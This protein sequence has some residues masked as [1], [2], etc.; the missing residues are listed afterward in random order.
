M[1]TETRQTFCRICESLC[2]LEVT[3]EDGKP[4]SIRPDGDHVATRGFACPKGLKQAALF[5]NPDRL[6][7]PMKRVGETYEPISWGQALS[8]IGAKTRLIAER[9]GAKSIGMYVGT[10]AGFGVLHPIFAQGFMMGLGSTTLY[11]PASQDCANKFAASR[12]I[13]GFP[14]LQPFPDVRNTECLIIVGANPVVSKWSFLQV[15]NPTKEIKDIIGRGGQVIVVDPRRTETAKLA[16]AHHYIQPG[17]DVFFYLSFLH[18]VLAQG[19]VNEAV[20]AAHMT[21]FEEL[22][23][24]AADWPAERTTDVTGIAPDILRN[25]V[26]AY[27]AADGA[28]LYSS[29][30]VNMG[31]NGTLAFWLQEAINAISGNL[32]RKGGTL[33]AKGVYDFPKFAHK[34]GLL[35][36]D[37]R[38]RIG[39]FPKVN[40]A[41]PGGIMADEILTPGEGQLKALFVTGGNPLL[42]MPNAGRLRDAFEELELLVCLDIQ[43]G[44]TAS[45]AHYVLPCTS[46]LERPDL[47]FIFPL[48]LGLQ[49]KPYVQATKALVAPPGEVRD[50]ATIYA[51]LANASGFPLFGSGL[52]QK[53]LNWLV[54]R[55]AR[56]DSRG[57]PGLPQEGILSLLLRITG[58]GSFG[59]LLKHPHGVARPDHEEGSFLG[60]RVLTEDGKIHLAPDMFVQAAS[61]LGQVLEGLKQE[62][63]ELR[64][65][66]KRHVKTHNSWTHNIADFVK[67][68]DGDTNHLY[69][70]PNDAMERQL[71]AGDMVDVS[72][73]VAVVRLPLALLE[74]LMPGTVAMP[75]G[76]GHQ[77][78]AGTKVASATKGVNVNALSADGADRL[79]AVSGMARLTGYIV[80]VAKSEVP[81]RASWTGT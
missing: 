68:R 17:S 50:E 45:K 37:E 15:P 48:M 63:G 38:S 43:M 11:A 8:E 6:T 47:P 21:G 52:L 67:G 57:Q 71:A 39:N 27:L 64:L 18:E 56:K 72:T 69:M 36:S 81:Q 35:M 76:W 74:D 44:E 22:K 59:K 32:D 70:H 78:N 58:N 29:T 77:H 16:S 12:Q 30:G 54:R 28:A 33:V 2:G 80:Q 23:A 24:L 31:G 20:I 66:T 1:A 26:S 7:C 40:D 51:Q 41:Y 3:I 46:P 5:D 75:H 25:L 49:A 34:N 62:Q 9:D 55:G 19:A 60:Q 42:T 65:I 79:E 61:E 13:Y 73:D 4:V 53:L 10:A 14:F